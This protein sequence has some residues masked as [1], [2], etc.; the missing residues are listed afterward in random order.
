MS[1]YLDYNASSPIDKRV[2]D[3]MI[4][5]YKNDYGNADSRTHDFGNDARKVVETAR[6][7]VASLLKVRSEEVFFTSGATESNNIALLGLQ[8]YGIKNKRKHIITTSIEH[9]AILE[10]CKFLKSNGFEIEFINPDHSGRIDHKD[11]LKRIRKDT[12][13]VSVMHANNETGIIQPVKEIGDYL[14]NTNI[15][16]HIDAT[17]SCGKLV[18][19]IQ[20][21]NYDMMS[22]TAHKMAGPQ[23]IGALVLRKRE[24]KLPPIKPIMFGGDQEHGLRP[25]TIPVALTAGFGKACEIALKEYRENIKLYKRIKVELIR[26]L[27]DS[28]L[29]YK[30]N[31]DQNCCI[32]NTLNISISNVN[33]EALMLAAKKYCGIS[34]GSACTS[35]SYKPS[36][37]LEAM[38]VS[39]DEIASSLR[40]S[41]GPKM[42]LDLVKHEFKSLVD[43]ATQLA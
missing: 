9:K 34:N 31:G 29:T 37:V 36:Y 3:E 13:L 16:F 28:G 24:Y 18:E 7:N 40:I 2:L 22:V 15:Y 19:E 43:I 12:L 21:L 33:S 11:I 35:Y 30:F 5:V 39:T 23:G 10:S 25:G 14:K 32:P 27:D 6:K 41:W 38:G 26:I 20:E 4:K 1:I 17:Q 8:E 42:N